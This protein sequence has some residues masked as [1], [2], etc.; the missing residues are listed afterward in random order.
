MLFRSST[1]SAYIGTP[2]V[3][4]PNAF[5]TGYAWYGPVSGANAAVTPAAGHNMQFRAESNTN[6]AATDFFVDEA[7][8]VPATLTTDNRGP[9]DIWQQ[10]MY[11]R[12]VE[13]VT[14]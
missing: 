2:T 5:T 11:D 1:A 8:L 10:F 4:A 13:L 12:S 7:I 3:Y 14:S 6:A 9:Q